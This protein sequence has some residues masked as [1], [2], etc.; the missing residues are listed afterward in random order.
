MD[1]TNESVRKK[2]IGVM[3]EISKNRQPELNRTLHSLLTPAEQE[4]QR[5]VDG[6]AFQEGAWY[7]PAHNV[8][9]P[10]SMIAICRYGSY[11]TF[12]I[13]GETATYIQHAP[14]PRDLVFV[15][16]LHDV[17]NSRMKIEETTKGA[18]WE[19]VDKRWTHMQIGSDMLNEQLKDLR[20][21]GIL[22]IPDERIAELR[23]IVATH[24]FPY[25]EGMPLKDP[26]ARAHRGADRTFVPS[27][28]SFWK[29][30]IAYCVTPKYLDGARKLGLE[31]TPET[32]LS[33]RLA[34]FYD[35]R[36]P[37]ST[38]PD[39]LQHTHSLDKRLASWN[40]GG[41][42]EPAYTDVEKRVIDAMLTRRSHEVAAVTSGS[43]HTSDDFGALFERAFV[44]ETTTL[45]SYAAGNPAALT[46]SPS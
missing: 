28:L 10:A 34:F 20:A 17:G 41:R 6:L 25:I 44:D 13:S 8:I 19:R 40:E 5:F 1:F 32:F 15:A 12:D 4:I 23:A 45:L 33:A 29:D 31:L 2:T 16:Q 3:Q 22:D 43:M 7:R 11:S 26:E 18:D 39:A 42:C 35:N 38:V 46:V 14:Y 27:V 30:F 24:D 37:L 21:R 36:S 9:V